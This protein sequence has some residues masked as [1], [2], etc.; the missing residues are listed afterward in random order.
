VIRRIR[1]VVAR[2]V[3]TLLDAVAGDTRVAWVIVAGGTLVLLL[4]VWRATR[5]FVADRRLATVPEEEPARSAREWT[6][7][8]D[9]HTAAGRWR[10]AVR[11]R[12]AALV[13]HLAESGTLGE[14]PGRTVR[15]LDHEVEQ[16]AP[17]LAS[18]VRRAGTV[19]EDVWYG[20]ADVGPTEHA[21]VA[22]AVEEVV[23]HLGRGR[24][25]RA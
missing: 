20:H 1:E 5:G 6:L 16:A 19:F 10:E 17:A 22:G 18:A 24:E 21:V 14:V 23:G 12:Y 13:A 25:V 7:A 9:E 3:Q 11:Y 8:A 2:F 15:E 4:V